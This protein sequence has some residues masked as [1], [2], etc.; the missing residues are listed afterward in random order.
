M[1][2]GLVT[3]AWRRHRDFFYVENMHGVDWDAVLEHYLPMVDDA[4]SRED[5][6]YI[7]GRDDRRAQC[8]SRVL[9]RW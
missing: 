7:I 4:V 3:D 8:R 5:V 2:S 1:A 6:S 9:L